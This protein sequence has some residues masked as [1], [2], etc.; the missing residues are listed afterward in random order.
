[1]LEYSRKMEFSPSAFTV[2]AFEHIRREAGGLD[3]WDNDIR[4]HSFASHHYAAKQ[5]IGWPEQNMG[6][7]A[8]VLRR[9]YL[10]RSVTEAQGFNYLAVS[11]S[12]VLAG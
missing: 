2:K 5:K 3:A 8:E 1:M 11:L 9:A 7:S 10:N 4:R 12:D 6:N